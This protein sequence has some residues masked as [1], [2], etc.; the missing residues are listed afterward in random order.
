MAEVEIFWTLTAKKQ[1]NQIFSYWNERNGNSLYSQKL[2][3]LIKVR[4]QLLKEHPELG[5]STNFKSTRMLVMGH[6]SII[7]Q[8]FLPKVIITGFWDNRR[9]PRELLQFLRS[10]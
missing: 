1:R 7:Y 3:Q 5:R 2:K 8:L 4:T 9:D 10:S 6:Y